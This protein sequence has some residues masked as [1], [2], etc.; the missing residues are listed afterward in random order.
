M[1][2]YKIVLEDKTIF[3]GA[4][5]FDLPNKALMHRQCLKNSYCNCSLYRYMRDN[6]LSKIKLEL[7]EENINIS[8]LYDKLDII[9]EHFFSQLN[10]CRTEMMLDDNINVR[11]RAQGCICN[12]KQTNYSDKPFILY[13][14]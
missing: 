8:L 4:T 2:I 12:K 13:F 3:Y 10:E 6:K 14:D 11:P 7:I 9:K 1:S 5:K